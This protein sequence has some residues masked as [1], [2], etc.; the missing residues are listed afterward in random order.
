MQRNG[1]PLRHTPLMAPL[2]ADRGQ[3]RKSTTARAPLPPVVQPF[4]VFGICSVG[5]TR[6][7]S[8]NMRKA[9]RQ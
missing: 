9:E 4:P 1:G 6:S 8:A 5:S 3:V 2:R 7:L